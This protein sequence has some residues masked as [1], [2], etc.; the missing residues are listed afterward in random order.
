M[1]DNTFT[2]PSELLREEE[3]LVLQHVDEATCYSLGHHI[4]KVGL[5]KGQPLTIS[6]RLGER[7]VF[8]AGLPGSTSLNDAVV[9]AKWNTARRSGHSS[10][11]QRNLWLD[12]GTTFEEATG[13]EF[14]DYAAFGG[15]VPVWEEATGAIQAFVIV[16]GLSQEEDHALAV[17]AIQTQATNSPWIQHQRGSEG[18]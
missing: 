16:S 18:R 7:S 9:T 10:L 14:P 5:T 3:S 8:H 15:A 6:V 1:P 2:S 13:L 17:S 11:Y 12:R 4:A